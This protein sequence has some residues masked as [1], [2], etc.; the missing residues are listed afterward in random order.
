M[1]V[2]RW[3]SPPRLPPSIHRRF[4]RKRTYHWQVLASDG[5]ATNAGPVWSFTTEA[6]GRSRISRNS[7]ERPTVD[8]AFPSMV[9]LGRASGA[10]FD[11]PRGLGHGRHLGQ[12]QRGGDLPGFRRHEFAPALLPGD[13]ALRAV[14]KTPA[15]RRVRARGLQDSEGQPTACRPGAPPGGFE[16]RLLPRV[17]HGRNTD[18]RGKSK[19]VEGLKRAAS[20]FVDGVFN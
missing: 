17:E 6:G 5:K 1:P 3:C 8:L 4:V 15:A 16:S 18:G 11:Q 7:N 13:Y 20:L 12:F 19:G 14:L 2:R 9:R 10:D